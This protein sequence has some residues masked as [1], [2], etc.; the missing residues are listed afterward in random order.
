MKIWNEEAPPYIAYLFFLVLHVEDKDRD[1]WSSINESLGETQKNVSSQNGMEMLLLFDDLKQRVSSGTYYCSNVYREGNR[2]YVGSIYSQLPFTSNEEKQLKASLL[3]QGYTDFAHIG[4]DHHYFARNFLP[5][6][7]IYGLRLLTK[8]FLAE[9][10]SVPKQITIDYFSRNLETY[11]KEIHNEKDEL[12]M[13]YENRNIQLSQPRHIKF[14]SA[15]NGKLTLK[16]GFVTDSTIKNL[17]SSGD[18]LLDSTNENGKELRIVLG[19]NVRSRFDIQK[20]EQTIYLFDPIGLNEGIFRNVEKGLNFS[21]NGPDLKWPVFLARETENRIGP[22]LYRVIEDDNIEHINSDLF[23]LAKAEDFEEEN[24]NIEHYKLIDKSRNEGSIFENS[25]LFKILGCEK[26]FK[27]AGRKV[28][29]VNSEVSIKYHGLKDGV[30]GQKSFHVAIPLQIEILGAEVEEVQVKDGN[31]D[32]CEITV[33][34]SQVQNSFVLD[35]LDV[36]KYNIA[37]FNKE[38]IK[39]EPPQHRLYDFSFEITN[40]FLDKRELPE[41][42]TAYK[43][44]EEERL[45]NSS[46]VCFD[47]S[48]ELLLSE[49]KIN[50]VIDLIIRTGAF[51]SKYETFQ[52]LLTECFHEELQKA[53]GEVSPDVMRQVREELLNVMHALGYLNVD[54]VTERVSLHKPYWWSGAIEGEHYLRGS[55]TLK[56]RNKLK[57]DTNLSFEDNPYFFYVR[58]DKKTRIKVALPQ[59]IFTKI[60]ARALPTL[61]GEIPAD[62]LDSIE[63]KFTN[64]VIHKKQ[65]ENEE[66]NNDE[67]H[68]WVPP[69]ILINKNNGNRLSLLLSD[70]NKLSYFNWREIRYLPISDRAILGRLFEY[71]GIRLYKIENVRSYMTEYHYILFEKEENDECWKYTYYEKGQGAKAK[72]DFLKKLK[73]IDFTEDIQDASKAEQ[74]HKF[75]QPTHS[76][77]FRKRN[78]TTG[79]ELQNLKSEINYFAS[80][81][82]RGAGWKSSLFFIDESS[83]TFG[84]IGYLRLPSE[85]ERALIANS[86]LAPLEITHTGISVKNT[87]DSEVF[88][89]NVG[90]KTEMKYRLYRNIPKA[91]AKKIKDDLIGIENLELPH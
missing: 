48:H 45:Q 82:L 22:N 61:D 35:K 57:E 23:V 1:Y 14:I 39:I 63:P 55:L 7:G 77:K 38:G 33:D 15:N 46:A 6:E 75:L 91:L 11:L 80:L 31:G 12:E 5:A 25:H 2:K 64:P 44:K 67:D 20:G 76:C 17:A 49:E 13:L 21:F 51:S 90:R 34:E 50:K 40:E 43:I 26:P 53:F 60:H 79:L 73:H 8:R 70:T 16:D 29:A 71:S 32:L 36:G 83:N 41:S 81:Q 3:G 69:A 52:M 42:L 30:R 88:E 27:V 54:P 56:E 18:L 68:S 24:S 85:I 58:N 10:D 65:I 74:V 9:G 89:K 37:L 87:I 47:E 66:Q 59:R 78:V 28:I 72:F 86:C 84:V 4:P 62:P 19:N